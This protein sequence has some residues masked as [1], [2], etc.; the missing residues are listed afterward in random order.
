MQIVK[1]KNPSEGVEAAKEI[2]YQTVTNKTV[3]L[4]SGGSTPKL[5]YQTLA[6]EQKLSPGA[7]AMIDERYG[8][9]LHF[10]SNELMIKNTKFL[11]YLG[12]KNIRFFPILDNDSLENTSIN[13]DETMR[14]VFNHFAK[15]VAIMGIGE[16]GHTAGIPIGTENNNSDL[17]TFYTNFPSKLNNRI[18]LT[19]AALEQIDLL[20]VLVFGK[21]KQ[22]ILNKIL[23]EGNINNFSAGIFVEKLADK[24]IFITDLKTQY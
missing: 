3:L 10:D 16:D 13:Y 23:K 17:V 5:L 14:F 22:K 12:L 4:L 6:K 20:I 24:T 15:T 19:Y 18:S 21:E 11:N 7:V 1:V 2:L 8:E 9:K